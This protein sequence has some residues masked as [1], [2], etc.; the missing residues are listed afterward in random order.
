MAKK[1]RKPKTPDPAA[2]AFDVMQ[3]VA[4]ATGDTPAAPSRDADV[5]LLVLFGYLVLKNQD[6]VKASVLLAAAKQSGITNLS[7]IDRALDA[8]PGL[9]TKGGV[10]R[11]SWYALTNPGIAHAERLAKDIFA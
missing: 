10:K 9:V 1:R 5:L 11:G 8:Y 2:F 4:A 3:H 6:E 7:R